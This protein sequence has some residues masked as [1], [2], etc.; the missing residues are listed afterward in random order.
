MSKIPTIKWCDHEF[1]QESKVCI[2]CKR[3]KPRNGFNSLNFGKR[4]VK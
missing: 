1:K 2:K 3:K 4:V